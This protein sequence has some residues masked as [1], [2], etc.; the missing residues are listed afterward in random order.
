VIVGKS[1]SGVVPK[2]GTAFPIVSDKELGINPGSVQAVNMVA[3]ITAERIRNPIDW[4]ALLLD[5]C[6]IS[7]QSDLFLFT[8]FIFMDFIG[9]VDF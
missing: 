5:L 6:F 7:D 3:A 8:N 4:K 9:F 2:T 1:G